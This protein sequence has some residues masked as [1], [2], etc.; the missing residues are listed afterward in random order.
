M[1]KFTPPSALLEKLTEVRFI[2]WYSRS[3]V[4]IDSHA[5]VNITT[6]NPAVAQAAVEQAAPGSS[7]GYVDQSALALS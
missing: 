3:G 1:I 7:S 4:T 2:F 6:N 5:T